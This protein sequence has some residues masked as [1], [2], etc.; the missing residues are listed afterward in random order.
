MNKRSIWYQ[1]LRVLDGCRTFLSQI[2]RPYIS[3]HFCNLFIYLFIP[4]YFRPISRK[5]TKDTK[6]NTQTDTNQT[7]E[8]RKL[9]TNWLQELDQLISKAYL[10]LLMTALKLGMPVSINTLLQYI[11]LAIQYIAL[12]WRL[13]PRNHANSIFRSGAHENYM[14]VVVENVCCF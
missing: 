13:T 6:T 11:A 9:L 4:F 14:K 2:F 5:N 12:S 10:Q 8:L 1:N 3:V 7:N